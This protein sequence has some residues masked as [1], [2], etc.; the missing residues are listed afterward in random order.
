VNLG[1]TQTPRRS[2]QGNNYNMVHEE[3]RYESTFIIK[4]SLDEDAQNAIIAKVE[5][6]VTKNGGTMIETERWGR[7]KLAYMIEKEDHAIYTSLHFRAL[8]PVIAKL[9]RV[10]QLDESIVRWLTLVMPDKNF[11]ARAAMKQRVQN[12]T[13][14]R[15][16]DAA[17][18][19]EAEEAAAAGRVRAPKEEVA[20]EVA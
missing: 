20:E 2:N 11:A 3:T 7:R 14:R 19:L 15:T 9:E 10:Y 13:A 16:L 12:V 18:A 6:A 1:L 4:A 8:G 5:D 17:N